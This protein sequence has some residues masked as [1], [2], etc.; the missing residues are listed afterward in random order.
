MWIK[1][2]K[3]WQCADKARAAAMLKLQTAAR[4]QLQSRIAEQTEQLEMSRA[5][6]TA[7]TARR[8]MLQKQV[9][10]L[11]K[12]R[13]DTQA[14]LRQLVPLRDSLAKY[15]GQLIDLRIERELGPHPCRVVLMPS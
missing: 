1:R 3:S 14:L 11:S 8:D 4:E 2:R 12:H 13:A 6:L 15:E 10:V 9:E 5:L 7:L